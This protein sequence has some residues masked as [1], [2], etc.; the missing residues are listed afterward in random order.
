MGSV[1][2][3]QPADVTGR[4]DGH[5]AEGMDGTPDVF[6]P[7]VDPD[8]Q[9]EVIRIKPA[10]QSR[11]DVR[12]NFAGGKRLL[13]KIQSFFT[14][15]IGIKGDLYRFDVATD[16]GVDLILGKNFDPTQ[17]TTRVSPRA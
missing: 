6:T 17:A 3:R 9:D 14:G 4:F 11:C 10:R 1:H 16:Q 13:H 15:F 2:A 7:G 5:S 12:R 8:G